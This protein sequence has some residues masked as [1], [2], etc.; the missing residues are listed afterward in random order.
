MII[1]TNLLEE[2]IDISHLEINSIVQALNRVGLEVESCKS[3]VLP[4][5]VIVAKVL[6]KSKHPDA[7]KL[8]VCKVDTGKEVLQIVCGAKNVEA[9]EYVALA[10]EGAILGEGEKTLKI[11]PSKLRGIESFG[12]LCSSTELGLPK[13]NDGIM[14]L[15]ESIG[16]LELGKELREYPIFNTH[17]LEISL[18]PNR[19]DCLCVLG[20]ARELKGI[21]NLSI[22][23]PK[24]YISTNQIGIGRKMQIAL[25]NKIDSSLLYK[26]VDF[27][28]KYTPLKI[29]LALGFTDNLKEGVLQNFIG[30]TTY[31]TGVLLN[32]YGADK[33]IAKQNQEILWLNVSSDKDGFERIMCGDEALSIIGVGNAIKQDL[34]SQCLIIFEASYMDPMTISQL[35]FR[36]K[37]KEMDK[38]IT[39][40]STRGS[41]PDL[42]FGINFL[43][44]EL[45][46]YCDCFIY[47]EVQEIKQDKEPNL[48]HTQFTNLTNIIGC[49]IESEEA[50]GIL[51]QLD[52]LIEVKNNATDS[53]SVIVPAHRHDI[54]NEQD[55]SEEILRIYGIDKIPS[56]P[57]FGR[58]YPRISATYDAYKNQRDI[59]TRALGYG[60]IECIHYLF[61]Q[62]D[63]LKK[64]GLEV[65]DEELD[66][67]NP[68][69]AELDTLRT[70]L[71]PAMLDS[72]VRNQNYGHK[73][74]KLCEIGSVYNCKRLENQKVAFVVSGLKEAEIYPHPKGAK[75]DFYSFASCIEGIVGSFKLKAYNEKEREELSRLFHPFQCAKVLKNNKQIG[76][77][78]KL[79]P[80][81]AKEMG[82]ID[83]FMC[84]LDLDG[85]SRQHKIFK[86][87][88]RLPRSYRDL[89]LHIDSD[90]S[91]DSLH[92]AVMEAKIE[93]LSKIYPLDIFAQDDSKLALSIRLEIC[94]KDKSLMDEDIN[95]VSDSVLDILTKHGAKLKV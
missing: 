5:K 78:A 20:I 18:T 52:F 43:C 71:I 17:M 25:K 33:L 55:L 51:K 93:Y 37:P 58:E 85:L 61:Y 22:K 2:F 13:L 72:I 21:F 49:E 41:N 10:M 30:Y 15:D 31:M 32:A 76:I 48:I 83:V 8:S 86:D 14:I 1:T 64:L 4:K 80:I 95:R 54:H 90:V 62:R 35:L 89:T 39:Y 24:E 36:I 28:A 73:N 81:L 87:F 47:D 92:Q 84:E 75:W 9:G 19:G 66:L 67:I 46:A 53:F 74:I 45:S 7:D 38:N 77:I 57:Y 26:V 16:V 56:R 59:I 88:S 42:K 27:N 23:K 3:I 68:I 6:E 69:T 44:L 94:P 50:F 29:A 65:V 79:N 63:R 70:S 91:F 40:R 60:F 11:K 82:L 12:M 34:D